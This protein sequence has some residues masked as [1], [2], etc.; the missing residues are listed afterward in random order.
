MTLFSIFRSPL[1]FGGNLP[2]N[3]EFTLSL[4]TNK[5]VLEVN[6]HST[7]SR[8]LFSKDGKIAWT[9][10]DPKTG[11]KYL[12]L[13]NTS[14]LI[15]PGEVRAENITVKLEQLGIEGTCLVKDLWNNKNLGKIKEEFVQSIRTHASGLYRI[16]EKKQQKQISVDNQEFGTKE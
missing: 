4:L 5:E 9:A 12:A 6:Q 8:Q 16:S 2:D 13:F 15:V 14:D 11:D 3:D 10:S 1:M 7:G